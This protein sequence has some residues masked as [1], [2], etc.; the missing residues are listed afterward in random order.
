[1]CNHQMNKHQRNKMICQEKHK[2][3]PDLAFNSRLEIRVYKYKF[4]MK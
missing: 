4:S 2:P 3:N 1:M